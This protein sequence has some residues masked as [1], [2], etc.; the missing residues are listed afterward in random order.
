MY[1]T[2]IRNRERFPHNRAEQWG[3]SRD[4]HARARSIDHQLKAGAVA[5]SHTIAPGEARQYLKVARNLGR[6][7]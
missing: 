3:R 5:K 4:S 2:T 6:I 7:R 1:H